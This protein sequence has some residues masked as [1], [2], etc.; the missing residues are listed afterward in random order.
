MADIEMV[1][2]EGKCNKDMSCYDGFCHL[3]V[4]DDMKGDCKS[5]RKIDYNEA[6]HP[7]GICRHVRFD[8]IY[9]GWTG[10]RYEI[11]KCDSDPYNPHLDCMLVTL[12]KTTYECVK[13]ILNG[14]CIYNEYDKEPDEEE[15]EEYEGE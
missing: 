6:T 8:Y 14:D 2:R 9:K 3:T 7:A 4:A 1:Y 12:G 15:Y 13:V 11:K 5:F 10:K